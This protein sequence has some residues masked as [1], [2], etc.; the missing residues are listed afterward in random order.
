M[1]VLVIGVSAM[2][3]IS[4]KHG[5]PKPYD[6]GN[7]FV[8]TPVQAGSMGSATVVG[9]GYKPAEMPIPSSAVVQSFSAY[10]DKFPLIL[11]LET[12]VELFMD[13]LRTV[14]VGIK[15]P[16]VLAPINPAPAPR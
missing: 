13:E 15:P 5:S 3:G 9:F 8:A 7:V 11:D 12:D 2:S 1:K 10:K 4:N 14:C 16:V 6:F